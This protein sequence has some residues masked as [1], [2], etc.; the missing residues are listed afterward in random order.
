[1]IPRSHICCGTLVNEHTY[2]YVK[3]EGIEFKF[4]GFRF[5]NIWDLRFFKIRF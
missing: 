5:L 1:M 2:T 3:G 4:K